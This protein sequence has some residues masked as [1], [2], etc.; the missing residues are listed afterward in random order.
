VTVFEASIVMPAF[1][2]EATI[3]M[4][5]ETAIAS[6]EMSRR[7]VAISVADDGSTDGTVALVDQIAAGSDVPI[8]VTRHDLNQGTGAA[9]NTAADAVDAPVLL[10]LDQ[11]DEYL[12]GHVETCL[13][14]LEQRPAIDALKT[15][16]L[17]DRP[18]HDDWV[19]AIDGSLTQNLAVRRYA[20][21]IIGG[22]LAD[23]DTA[24]VGCDD[25][26]YNRLLAEFFR[27]EL[28][29]ERTVR[30][31]HHP[32]NSFDRQYEAKFSRPADQAVP[33]LTPERAASMR[34]VQTRFEIRRRAVAERVARLPKRA[35]LAGC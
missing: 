32:G 21:R 8:V 13:G 29:D 18:V 22:F 27:V 10:F 7:R 3:A 6:V 14:A 1:N 2:G 20:H 26:L 34:S 30:F 23:R 28:I 15:R 4:A 25:V 19:E 33:T 31:R 5:I 12:P 35:P 24:I 9:R 11:D 17:L 16:A